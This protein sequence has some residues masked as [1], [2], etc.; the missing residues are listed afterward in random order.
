MRAREEKK[1]DKE[2]AKLSKDTFVATFDLQAVIQTPCSLVS[3]I[4]YMRKLN[5]YNLSIYN[6]ATQN[7]T[8]YLWSEIDTNRGACEIATCLYLQLLALPSNFKNA[9]LYSDA[10]SGQNRNQ[11]TATSL[12]H[13]VTNLPYLET[14]EYTFLEC[15]HT[16]ME[17]DSMH[18]AIEF[19]KKKTEIYVPSQWATVVRMARRKNPYL[20]VPV[21]YEDIYDFKEVTKSTV[22][23]SKVDTKGEKVNWLKIKWLRFSKKEP[24]HVQFKFSYDGEFHKMKVIDVD[25]KGKALTTLREK[26]CLKGTS[27]SR[28]FHLL[29]RK[30]Y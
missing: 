9:I 30:I 8:C 17:C 7:V 28:R 15:G 12:L 14:I 20:V 26:N 1:N 25:K 19:A 10:C 2:S 11:F 13:A 24:E 18:S 3:Q 21:Q 29:R 27:V 23:Y 4:Y 16:Q 5:C 22:K 6:L